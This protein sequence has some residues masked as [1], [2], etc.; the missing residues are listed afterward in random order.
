[1]PFLDLLFKEPA[2]AFAWVVAI[3]IAIG[4]HEFSHALVAKLQGD[5]TAELEGRVT[6]NP[7]AHLDPFGFLVLVLFGFGWG[8]P[9]PFNPYNLKAR[10]W[11]PAIVSLAG[12]AMNVIGLIVFG[13]ILA[14]LA[15]STTLPSDNL[16]VIFLELLVRFNIVLALFNLLPIPPLDGSKLLGLLPDQFRGLTEALTKYGF[17]ILM[18]VIVFGQPVLGRLFNTIENMAFRIILPS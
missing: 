10:R 6:L 7:L 14:I 5:S 16:L 12:P 13:S 18:F 1:M 2:I 17:V 8:K 11:G 9:V 4:I 3:V 15:R